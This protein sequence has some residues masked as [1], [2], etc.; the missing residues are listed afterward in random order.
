MTGILG[1]NKRIGSPLDLPIAESNTLKEA[2]KI[3]VPA[4]YFWR[5]LLG[6][7]VIVVN[8]VSTLILL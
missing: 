6:D 7:S 1:I 3:P 2:L 4:I 5:L 8:L